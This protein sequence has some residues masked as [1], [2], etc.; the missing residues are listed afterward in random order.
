MR[1]PRIR[2]VS[3]ALCTA[4]AT[5]VPTAL[6]APPAVT[7]EP[8]GRAYAPPGGF[9]GPDSVSGCHVLGSPGVTE[10]I[11]WQTVDADAESPV[12]V[13]AFSYQDQKWHFLGCGSSGEGV[14]PWGNV[15]G[16]PKIR[17]G[18]ALTG[19]FVTWTY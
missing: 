5:T 14:I 9:W 1:C 13:Q 7:C 19:T 18:S 10:D 16:S 2:F 3:L 6:A 12:C 17:A 4:V 11:V 15:V 8:G